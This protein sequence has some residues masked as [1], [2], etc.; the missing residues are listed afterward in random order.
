M[1]WVFKTKHGRESWMDLHQNARSCPASRALLVERVV[2]AGWTV[3]KAAEAQGLSARSAYR[4]LRRY[5]ESGQAGLQDRPSTPLHIPRRLGKKEQEQLL[6]LRSLRL[7]GAEIAGRLQLPRSTVSRWLR[8][9]G[10][11]RLPQ[12]APPEPIRRYEK[13]R[14]G[15]LL[16]LDIKKLGRIQGVG[17]RITGKRQHANRGIGWDFVHVAIDDASRLAYA[18][19]LEDQRGHSA[20]SFLKRAVGWFAKR[21]VK[22]ERLLTDNGSCYLADR[23]AELCRELGLKHSRTRPYRPRTNGKAER[24]IQTLQREWAY[25]FTFHASAERSALLPR[26]LHFYNH[27]R[28]HTALGARPPISRLSLNNAVRIHN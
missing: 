8:R 22:V 14:P 5:R 20:T 25:A 23:F 11:G 4:W 24:F 27:H 1:L 10:L 12:L 7:S 21:G 9:M 15:E 18:E 26:Y 13:S 19:I 3:Q 2:V 6:A 16:H 17:H 28:A